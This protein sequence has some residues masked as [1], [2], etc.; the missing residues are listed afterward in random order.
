MIEQIFDK[1]ARTVNHKPKLVLG[2]I[3]VVLVVALIGIT[4]ISMETGDDTY[5]DRYSVSGTINHQYTKTF[6]TEPIVLIVETSDPLS[7]EVL[8]YL[9][10]LENNIQQQ[11]NIVSTSSVVDLLKSANKG[12]LPQ[13]KGEIDAIV[14]KIPEATRKVTIPSNVMSFMKVTMREGLSDDIKISTLHNI[15]SL[16]KSSEP[17]AGVGI[18]VSGTTAFDDQ[19]KSEMNSQMKVLIVAAMALMV[20][21]IG[22]LYSKVRYRFLPVLFVG[23]GIISALGLMGLTGIHLN[24]VVIGAFPVII[25]L[26]VDYAIQF[27][28]RLDEETRKGTL[29]NAIYTTITKTGPAV[30]YAMLATSVGIAA[31]FISPVPMVR[32][33]GL[34]AIIGL[35]I[36]YCITLLGITAT[37][38]ILNYKPKLPIIY[39][40]PG[41]KITP[42]I[43]NS[44][45]KERWSY[46]GALTN[47]SMKI[48]KKPFIILTIAVLI[49]IVGLQVDLL[50]PIEADQNNFV[51]P[52][53]PAK[54]QMDKI[55]KLLGATGTSDFY[56]QGSQ[57]L[58]IDTIQW[59]KK[60]EDYSLS[61]HT[62]LTSSE[63]IVTYIYEYNNGVMPETQS[64]LDTILKKI[65]TNIKDRYV[66]G[67]LRGVIRFSTIDMDVST[68]LNLK[69]QMNDD[70]VF[71]QPPPGVTVQPVGNFDIMTT[72]RGSLAKSKEEI[73]YLGFILIFLFLALVYR[74]IHAISPL[75]PIILVVSWNS[76]VMYLLGISYTPLTVVLSSMSIGVAAEFSILVMERYSE[77]EGRL[78]N[79]NAAIQESVSKI[80]A[81]IT[82]SGLATFFGFSALCLSSFPIISNF[83]ITT[84]IAVA[85]SLIGAIIIMP[86]VLSV[87][88]RFIDWLDGRKKKPATIHEEI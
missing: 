70:I 58:N 15:Q 82:V 24:V 86:A 85:F 45:S 26:G 68:Q 32:S 74:H 65:Q 5:I 78:H 49:A 87:M 35:I 48:A 56:I 59:M 63:S 44:Y 51:P 79:Y 20:L 66:S 60:F 28:S 21:V 33:F 43:I 3:G 53:M 30:M 34:V 50:I 27:H 54:V 46:S 71:L 36:C 69:N 75:I 2:F 61:K 22:L 38:N 41:T 17:P 84:L 57:I 55:N 8:N 47:L 19:F 83:G 40:N 16:V 62:E 81:A 88:G 31:M 39:A 64:Q 23:F 9:N 73:T 80:G 6:E 25:G 12:V 11:Q 76:V 10:R 77:E 37:A 29:Q 7:P 18:S 72:L 52:L 14:Q 67:S 1:V 4:M 42:E 13:S